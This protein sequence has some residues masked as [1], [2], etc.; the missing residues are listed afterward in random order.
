MRTSIPV[1]AVFVGALTAIAGQV[2][3]NGAKP[4]PI[5]T[6]IALPSLGSNAQALGT[7]AAGTVVVGQSFDRSDLLYAVKWTL[8]GGTWVISTLPLPGTAA[9][10]RSVDRFGN[11][12]GHDSST[13]QFPVLW[14]ATGGFSILGCDGSEG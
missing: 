1:A 7:N 9:T 12:A 4:N 13:P 8:Q 10:A 6:M 14:P 5:A 3:V 2:S 11:I